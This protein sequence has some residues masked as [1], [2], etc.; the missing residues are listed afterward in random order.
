MRKNKR[1]NDSKFCKVSHEYSRRTIFEMG[2]CDAPPH[3]LKDSNVNLK[4]KTTKEGVGGMF[5][6]S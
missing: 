5:P 2:T 3:S 4:V 1:I 6:N